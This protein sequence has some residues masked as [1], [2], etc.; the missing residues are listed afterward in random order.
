MPPSH[1][2]QDS[3]AEFERV[4]HELEHESDLAVRNATGSGRVVVSVQDTTH[5]RLL[6]GV[7]VQ[8]HL[9]VT[10]VDAE[11]LQAADLL[12]YELILTTPAEAQLL[13]AR[14]AGMPPHNDAVHPAIISILPPHAADTTLP[15]LVP[16]ADGSIVLPQE[17]NSLLAQVSVVLYAHRA[18]A[19]RYATAMEE[20]HL[21]RRIFKSVTSGISVAD[22][23]LPDMPLTYVNPAF[24]VMTGY[25][26]ESVVGRNCRFLQ[27]DE[28]DQPGIALLREGIAQRKQVTVTLR[29]YRKDGSA[30]WNEL[31]ISP[32]R[33][34]DGEL[35][36]YVGI[37]NDIS[38][39][40]EFE[41]ALRQSEKL[42]A[43]GR[44]AA[45]IAHE[46]NNPLESVMNLLY[47][48][49]SEQDPAMV[50]HYVSEA[51]NEVKRIAI[52]TTQSLRFYRQNTRPQAMDC[53]DLL[54]SVLELYSP[55]LSRF[56]IATVHDRRAH[57]P[58]VCMESEVRQVL[59]NMVR[60]AIDAMRANTGK[61]EVRTR[62]KTDWQTGRRGVALTVA[63]TGSGI[64]PDVIKKLYTAFFTTKGDAGT[65][66][67]LW[68]S[69]NIVE[70][71]Q[72]RLFV[73]SSIDP[74][75][76]GTVFVMFLPFDGLRDPVLSDGP[77]L[78]V[79]TK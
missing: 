10:R 32:I 19:R 3:L 63:D 71:H 65:G 28:R 69:A 64:A 44:L 22:A 12:S 42:A 13:Q 4:Q 57:A 31:F 47:L 68:V 2:A 43:V 21:N 25:S 79:A 5:L 53:D 52:I 59:S 61:L 29:N 8:L 55:K 58:V 78:E 66:L 37:Q 38:A 54:T 1:A 9:E 18:F 40:M 75:R 49:Q 46:I 16:P 74:Q 20:L 70:R 35:T 27:R 17:P 62:V 33:N 67:G 77:E 39:R 60:N 48:A 41:A 34:R 76:H 72:G 24:E 6:E 11:E 73:R 51:D 56:N 23:T 36:H 14:L 30:F 50:K 15:R 26:L 45:S 7:A